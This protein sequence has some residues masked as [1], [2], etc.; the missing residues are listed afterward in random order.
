MGIIGAAMQ[1][2]PHICYGMPKNQTPFDVSLPR[3]LILSN[4]ASPKPKTVIGR[5]PERRGLQI[6]APSPPRKHP[7]LVQ[8]SPRGSD[9]LEG[10]GSQTTLELDQTGLTR[11]SGHAFRPLLPERNTRSSYYT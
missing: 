8:A 3:N 11:D 7:I 4:T 5:R 9:R 2:P 6:R 10:N 1:P